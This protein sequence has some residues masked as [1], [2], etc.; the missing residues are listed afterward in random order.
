MVGCLIR[1]FPSFTFFPTAPGSNVRIMW[2]I[3]IFKLIQIMSKLTLVEQQIKRAD[4]TTSIVKG[5]L[6]KVAT[7]SPNTKV[8]SNGK[9]YGFVLAVLADN[10]NISAQTYVLDFAKGDSVFIHP[11][12]GDNGS[13][14]TA[15]DGSP[16][17][18]ATYA[19]VRAD[20][21]ALANLFGETVATPIADPKIGE[22]VLSLKG[23]DL[24]AYNKA[25]AENPAMSQAELLEIAGL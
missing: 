2:A 19:N 7:M 9:T 4:G 25:K 21:K 14:I 24:T 8:N 5:L 12:L 20:N 10:T 17:F 23:A 11:M 15:T 18:V 16:L 13:Q 6:A 3:T 22:R 1:P